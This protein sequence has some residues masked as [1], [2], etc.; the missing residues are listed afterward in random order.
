MV[1]LLAVGSQLFIRADK[2]GP[3]MLL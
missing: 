2:Q 1:H 3:E